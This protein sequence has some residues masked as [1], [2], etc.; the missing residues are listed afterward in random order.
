LL[1]LFNTMK[2]V[3][4]GKT[5][6]S[7]SPI[8]L[9]CWQFAGGEGITGSFWSKV[10]KKQAEEIVNISLKEGINWF[11]TA[12]VYGWGHSERILSSVLKELKVIPGKVVIATKWFPLF[13]NARSIIRTF[14]NRT[15]ALQEYP[16]DLYQIH[17][18]GSFSSIPEQM[19]KMADLLEEQKIRAIGV[20]NFNA[21]QMRKAHE[22]LVKRG[23]FLVSNQ[24]CYNLL[25]RDIERNGIL[26]TAIELGITIIAYSPL[27]Q[28]ILTGKFHESGDNKTARLGLRKFT[29][30][31]KAKSLE[32]SRPLINILR[33]IAAK[34]G[35]TISQVALTWIINSHKGKIVAIPGA[36]KAAH[37]HSNAQALK[38]K[39]SP[40][41]LMYIDEMSAG[42]A[43][44]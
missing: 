37:A 30:Q 9:G 21:R 11:D 38:I 28:G 33:E 17:F 24:V 7:I 13:R 1:H 34:K 36:S 2:L 27:A 10:D 32:K 4:L 20:S 25:N 39:L 14:Q 44:S 35:G 29:R 23:L 22:T 6:I 41:E 3:K 16:V 12:E 43:L 26:Q 18:P 15:Q 31:F 8:G 5:D 19:N 40:E 42:V